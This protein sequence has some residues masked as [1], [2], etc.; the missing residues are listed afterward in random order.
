MNSCQK[1]KNLFYIIF[2]WSYVWAGDY[3][4][5]WTFYKDRTDNIGCT[6]FVKSAPNKHFYLHLS[7]RFGANP[8]C[9]ESNIDYLEVA[10]YNE[11]R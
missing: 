7:I 3:Q 11:V 9:V 4:N 5:D 8:K 10:C 6:A 1:I 2:E